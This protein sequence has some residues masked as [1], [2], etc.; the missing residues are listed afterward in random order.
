[1][2][3]FIATLSLALTVVQTIPL[4]AAAQTGNYTKVLQQKDRQFFK[5]AEARRIGDQLLLYQRNTGGWPK[6]TDMVRPLSAQQQDSVRSQQQ[7]IDD[8]TIDNKATTLQMTFL[9]QLYRQ[10]G[11]SRYRDGFRKGLKFLLDSQYDN[12]GWPQFWPKMRDYQPHITYNDNAIVNVLKVL[13]DI[14]KSKPPYGAT[15]VNDTLRQQARR[16]FDKAIDCILKTQIMVDGEPTVWCQQ[17]DHVTLLPAKARAYELPSFCTLE[18]ANL[19]FLLM[20]LPH[21]DERIV[22]AVNG[23]MKWLDA[24][25]ITGKRLEQYKVNGKKD[26]RLVEDARAKPVWARYY[27][28]EEGKPFF[29]D[30]DGL[31]K[32]SIEEIGYERRNGY[33]WYNDQ[34]Q[35]LY[36]KY[37]DWAT[38]NKIKNRITLK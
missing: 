37:A 34:A 21:P 10:T 31:P 26:I 18:S 7:R 35:P 15:L 23:A 14:I 32:R 20:Q 4:T 19:V 38:K 24:H 25:K 33:G 11:D 1:M 16:A 8:S 36:A 27:D 13:R 30:R 9:A 2:N 5:T 6:N 22:R 29:C 3:H 28:L 12:G 17:H